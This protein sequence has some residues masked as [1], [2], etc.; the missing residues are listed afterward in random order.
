YGVLTRLLVDA[1]VELLGEVVVPGRYPIVGEL[2][3]DK[4][5]S[6]AGGL[7]A[8]ADL[9]SVEITRFVLDPGRNEL[10]VERQTHDMRLV[11]AGAIRVSPGTVVLVNPL[12]SEQEIG[13][14]EIRGEVKRPGR[15]GIVRGEKLSSLIQRAGGLQ[16]LA[17]PTGA[18]FMRDSVRRAEAN[19][20]TRAAGEFH[21]A[22]IG[23][24]S[25]PGGRNDQLT[26]EQVDL[27]TDLL[28]RL[29]STDVIGRM[30]VEMNP[31]VLDQRPEFDVSLEGGDTIVIPRRPLSVF[32]SGEVFNPGAQ[33]FT[34]TSSIRDY[35][36]A[37]GGITD[38]AD[39]SNAFII[40]PNGSAERINLSVWGSG[41]TDI[42]PGSW[43]VVPRNLAPFRL[44][45]FA[46]TFTQIL[47]QLAVS[48]ASIAV[49][50][51]N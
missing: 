27:M 24:V 8:R 39:L 37:A 42:L 43:I 44:R 45:E 12:I 46:T 49:I 25:E 10:E 28:T 14:V 15:Y 5:L 48:A 6:A 34:T 40:R 1:S 51:R 32:V 13:L 7:A 22:L 38:E 20:R 3:L 11:A 36:N 16:P 31:L 23:R 9:S 4:V 2:S 18:V 47:S 41:N 50:S 26:P 21:R 29:Q 17:Y 19:A 35:L 33:Q 30:V